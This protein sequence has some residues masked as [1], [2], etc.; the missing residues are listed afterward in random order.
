LLWQDEAVCEVRAGDT[1][2]QV[3]NHYEHTFKGG[4]DG[5]DY[6]VFGTRHPVEYGWLPRSRAVRL[7]WPW[8]EGRTD[9]P[10]DVEAEVGELEFAGPGER[11]PN[12]VAFDD[13]PLD[14]D[15]DK[16]LAAAAGAEGSGLNWIRPA[17]GKR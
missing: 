11:P 6:L 5:L 3:A 14:E 12:V 2:V 1:V 10:W 16:V 15:G 13:L 17:P 4:P 7:S 8:I 9:D